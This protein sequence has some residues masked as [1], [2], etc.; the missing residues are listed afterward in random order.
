MS[1]G[2]S[3]RSVRGCR[4]SAGKV[5]EPKAKSF[6]CGLFS[7]MKSGYKLSNRKYLDADGAPRRLVVSRPN[8]K[9]PEP[10]RSL[11]AILPPSLGATSRS[12]PSGDTPQ[13]IV[14]RVPVHPQGIHPGRTGHS[15]FPPADHRAPVRRREV[16]VTHVARRRDKRSPEARDN[17]CHVTGALVA[18][19]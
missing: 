13:H 11:C 6:S 15:G 4:A 9:W 7:L 5:K 3:T 17:T 18:P 16:S 12:N 14:P 19:V 1:S 10:A 8:S 2:P